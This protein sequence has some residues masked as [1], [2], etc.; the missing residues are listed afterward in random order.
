MATTET[1]V[2]TSW[3][4]AHEKL[5]IVLMILLASSWGFSKYADLR[6]AQ[7]EARANSAEQALTQ[8]KTQDAQ[9]RATVAQVT[10][11]YAAIVQSLQAQN[12]SLSASLAQR[13]VSL[14]VQQRTD[15]SLPLADLANRLKT[16]GNAPEGSVSVSGSQVTLT[17]P[18]AI[19]VT[20]TLEQ[21]PVL[22]Q[23]LKDETTIAANGQAELA[24]ANVVITEQTKQVT[25][26]K[27]TIT[28]EEKACTTQ[29][30]AVK[31]EGRK[32]SIKWFRRGVLVGIFGGLFAGHYG[33]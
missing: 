14:A 12:A 20:T 6:V 16:L 31:A 19:S 3:L 28:D 22:Q 18:G 15:A 24:Q 9:N 11:Q 33:L 2:A 30:A 27:L 10:Q 25:G 32:N 1:V 23:D 7:T 5:L 21:V 26:L 13:Q 17:Q 4:K 29:V 8:A